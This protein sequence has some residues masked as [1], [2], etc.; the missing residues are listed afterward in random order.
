MAEDKGPARGIRISDTMLKALAALIVIT[1]IAA[2]FVV[3][4]YGVYV[5]RINVGDGKKP[6]Y[7]ISNV[8]IRPTVEGETLFAETH[9]FDFSDD[10]YGKTVKI[11]FIKMLRVEKKFE[12]LEK[13][14]IQVNKD[15]DTARQYVASLS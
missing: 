14:T 10:L 5:T 8:G 11:E 2:V 3:P 7:G 9:I 1:L 12:D 13:L 6:L 15:I 4:K